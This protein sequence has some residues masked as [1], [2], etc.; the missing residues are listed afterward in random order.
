[1]IIFP[2]GLFYYLFA[3]VGFGRPTM[4]LGKLMSRQL[5]V[6]WVPFQRRS[7]SMQPYFDYDLEFIR[8]SFKYRWLRPF[9]YILKAQKTL[10]F[11]LARRPSLFWIQ[12]PPNFLLHL[13]YLYQ[14][15]LSP[16]TKIIAD[17][18]NATFRS[19]WIRIP[20]TV[21]LLNHCDLVIVHNQFVLDQAISLGI[22]P[23]KI[24]VLE[25]PPAQIAF[26]NQSSTR[27]WPH[28]L[29]VFPCSFNTD[30]PIQEVLEASL[31]APNITFALTGNPNRA[32]GI[33]ILSGLPTNVK[34][35]GFLSESDFNHL[36]HEAD[37]I[38]GLT[39]LDGIQL[40]VANEA[41]GIGKPLVLSNTKTLSS[42]F[43]QG[44]IFV[45]SSQPQSIAQGCINA[46]RKADLLSHEAQSLRVEREKHWQKQADFILNT[47][48][49]H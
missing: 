19:P 44:A 17:C 43:N 12:L 23:D 46:L 33:H 7:L 45:E 38:L 49:V 32:R 10:S 16:K 36:L 39:K 3:P 6:A 48:A 27:R 31:L 4:F 1:M 13:S 20:G 37:V 26:S 21:S 22:H 47:L 35:T 41:I 9:E 29:V 11:L 40:S 24:Q 30:E 42:L 8:L 28:P 34:L 5:F 14:K 18:H 15:I 25:D 2:K